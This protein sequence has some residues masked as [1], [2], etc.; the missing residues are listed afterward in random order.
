MHTFTHI[1]PIYRYLPAFYVQIYYT[2]W[3]KKEALTTLVH[4]THYKSIH[5]TAYIQSCNNTHILFWASPHGLTT[6]IV[7]DI[8]LMCRK[9]FL[10]WVPMKPKYKAPNSAGCQKKSG[11]TLT[12]L[13]WNVWASPQHSVK[14]MG[15]VC[16]K[17]HPTVVSLTSS[18]LPVHHLCV[19]VEQCYL[20]LL[21]W[22][23]KLE[24]GDAHKR[25]IAA[26]HNFLDKF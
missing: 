17:A 21:S 8:T 7:Q 16:G 4:R 11:S 1:T 18:N 15:T 3:L 22:N 13:V 25:L 2:L 20:Q 26:T 19:C 6:I 23:E 12:Y 10:S 5:N 24:F 9:W 14:A